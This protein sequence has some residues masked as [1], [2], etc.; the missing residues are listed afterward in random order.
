MA[1]QAPDP[2]ADLVWLPGGYPELYAGKIAS[3]QTFLSGLKTF[4][5]KKAVHGECGGYMVM[6]KILIDSNGENHQMAGL[7]GL[8]TSFE[9]RK[10]NLGYRKAKILSSILSLQK[11]D[12]ISGHEFHYSTIIDQPDPPLAEITDAKNE[13]VKETGSRVDLASGTFFH[14]IARLQ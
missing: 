11:G 12:I 6:G 13:L 4:V 2:S 3:S 5:K 14:M 7:L 9:K 8:V 1:D 10:M